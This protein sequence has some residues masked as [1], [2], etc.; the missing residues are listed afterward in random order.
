MP[1]VVSPRSLIVCRVYRNTICTR[2]SSLSR[3][4]VAGMRWFVKVALLLLVLAVGTGGAFGQSSPTFKGAVDVVA[5]NVV[6][7]DKQQQFVGGLTADNFAVYEDGVQQELSFF[8]AGEVPLDLAILL[9]TSASMGNKLATAQQ[10]GVRFVSALRPADR[11]LV[12]DIHDTSNILAP[13][14]SGADAAKDAIL[15]TSA[16]GGT[17]LY[18]GLYMALKE[19]TRLRLGET[20][21]R[22]QALVLLT[23]GEDTRSLVSY[24][25]VME[26]A[27]QSGISIYTIVLGSKGFEQQHVARRH[28]TATRPEYGMKALAQET[29]ARSYFALE[30]GDLA[31][32]YTSIGRE[33]ANQYA[34]GYTSTN[35]RRDGA[36]RR[37]VVR[38]LDRGGA[39]PRTRAGY[40]AP[41]G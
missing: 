33:L 11:V 28:P 5:L 29:G 26:L 4:G 32:A 22:R 14:R 31:G 19:M 35:P 36:Y 30:V 39:Q 23:D 27:K 13:L 3:L 10:A 37:V 20:D 24:D 8:A 1:R 34:L 15:R 12:V 17:A 25:D 38:I 40:L 2:P 18:N 9:D 6:V 16:R 21:L 7:V 41:R